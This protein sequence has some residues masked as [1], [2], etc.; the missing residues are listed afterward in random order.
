MISNKKIRYM[1]N[2]YINYIIYVMS[3]GNYY[4]TEIY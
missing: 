2:I 4:I 1:Y 3:L